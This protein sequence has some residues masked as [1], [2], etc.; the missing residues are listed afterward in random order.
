MKKI[1]LEIG[2]HSDVG[3]KRTANEDYYGSFSGEF[4]SLIIVC[5]GVGGVKGGTIASRK[6]VE[7]IKSH[8]DS[9]SSKYDPQIELKNALDK[10]DQ[11][12]KQIAAES[13]ELRE[14]GSTAVVLLIKDAF[15]YVAHIGDSRLYLIRGNKINQITTD[16]SLVQEMLKAGLIN[17]EQ[18][19]THPK[20]N[21]ITRALGPQGGSNPDITIPIEIYKDDYFILCTDGLTGYVNDEELLKFVTENTP[22]EACIKLVSLANE[23]GG[24]D[25]I[26]VQ[27]V[28][29]INGKKYTISKKINK[30]VLRVFSLFTAVIALLIGLFLFTQSEFFI[31]NIKK[32]W[33]ETDSLKTKTTDLK[34]E[35]IVDTVKVDSA[36][37][38]SDSLIK[39]SAEIKIRINSPDSLNMKK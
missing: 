18:A 11:V 29:V 13:E 3:R 19:K 7:T 26:T 15:A 4:G 22:Q 1:K 28:K 24:K 8:F 37:I 5:D 32:L 14:L 10:A 35:K 39:S 33:T 12:L 2:N 31:K 9:L 27:V 17:E 20:K 16:H 6:T 30:K 23:R 36:M 34:K 38:N 25:N 21:I